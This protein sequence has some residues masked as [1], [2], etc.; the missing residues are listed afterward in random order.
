MPAGA[1]EFVVAWPTLWVVPAWIEAHCRIPDGFHRGG[2]YELADWQLWCTLNHY[3]VKPDALPAGTRREDG[4]QVSVASAFHYRRSLIVGPQKCGKGPLAAATVAAEGVGPV[5]F[6]GWAVGGDRYV[7]EQHG[8]S[9]GWVYDYE[10]GEPMGSE[11]PTPLIQLTATSEDQVDNVYRPLKAMIELGPLA[12]RMLIRED[13]IRLPNS[14]EIAVVT[15]SAS[16]R[17]GNPVTFPL[18]DESGLYTKSNKLDGVADTQRRGAAGMGGRSMEHTNC[19]DPAQRSTAQQTF[20]GT[21]EDVFKFYRAPPANLSYRNKRERRRIHEIVYAGSWWVDLDAIDAEAAELEEKEP[22]QAER[23]FGN[24]IV[25]GQG[26]WLAEGL[27]ENA[28]RP[29]SGAAA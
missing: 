5:V 17:L 15:A 9:C 27:W 3:R 13:F 11:W 1:D 24:K 20:E 7:C 6:V 29:M 14:G 8:C 18:Q 22:G 25:R 23:F 2:P 12:E 26:T 19:W 10:P 16:S 28:R 21:A 4:D